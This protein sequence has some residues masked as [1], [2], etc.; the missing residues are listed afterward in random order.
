[1]FSKIRLNFY[2][3]LQK[4]TILT[5][6]LYLYSVECATLCSKSVVILW[7]INQTFQSAHGAVP[8][9]KTHHAT[10]S[11]LCDDHPP[12]TYDKYEE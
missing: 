5:T 9:V 2:E 8:Y 11:N 10:V 12:H 1:M 3:I 4:L 6:H 7:F